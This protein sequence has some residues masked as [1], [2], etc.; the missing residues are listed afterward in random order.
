MITAGLVKEL[1]EKTGVGMMDCKKALTQSNGNLEEAVKFLREK[2]LAAASKKADRVAGEGKIF[3]AVNE[4]RNAGVIAE[5]NCETDFVANNNDFQDFGNKVSSTILAE[6]N[7]KTEEDLDNL[8]IDGKDYKTFTSEMVL[9]LGENI[10]VKKCEVVNTQGSV[11]SYVHMNGKLG[12]LV[13]FDVAEVS[14]DLGKD[15]SMHI[16]AANPLYFRA[17][18]VPADEVNKEKEIMK[19]QVRNSGRPEQI[20]DKIVD[21]KISKYF[22]GICLL[23]QEFVKDPARTVKQI[24]PANVNIKSFKRYNLG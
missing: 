15:I 18:D 8:Y 13:E 11:F 7:I 4:Q 20:L 16:A 12:V 3:I 23:E 21:G 14:E 10:V 17:E 9:K 22:K 5:I 2:G 6:G 19:N 1:R 24:L